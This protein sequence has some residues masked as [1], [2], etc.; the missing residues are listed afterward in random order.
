MKGR[1]LKATA[2]EQKEE[3]ITVEAFTCPITLE[4][5]KEPVIAADGHTY[6]KKAILTWLERHDTSPR[7]GQKLTS[8]LVMNNFALKDSMEETLARLNKQEKELTQVKDKLQEERASRWSWWDLC[9]F[10][11]SAPEDEKD[12]KMLKRRSCF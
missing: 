4:T 5:F 6:E 7:T 1:E 12:Q 10:G 11:Q 3:P 2:Q 9:F 8:K